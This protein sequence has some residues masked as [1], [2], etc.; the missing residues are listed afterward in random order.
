M[1]IIAYD[2]T[3]NKV[4]TK[5]S[6]FINKFGKKVQYSVYEVRNSPRVLQNILKEIELTYKQLFQGSDSILIF[7]VCEGDKKKIVRYGYA[8]NDNEEVLIF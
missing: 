8:A 4:R 2:F 5:F 1:I 7:Q 3:D 6:K